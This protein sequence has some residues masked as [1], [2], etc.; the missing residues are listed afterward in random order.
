MMKCNNEAAL[1]IAIDLAK[2]NLEST[3]GWVVPENVNYF[4]EEV[5]NFLTGEKSDDE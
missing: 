3:D 4:I 2:T 5:Y 1:K